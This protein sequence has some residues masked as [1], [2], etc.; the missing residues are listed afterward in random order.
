MMETNMKSGSPFQRLK[1]IDDR[2]QRRTGAEDGASGREEWTGVQFRIGDDK[3]LAPMAM[4]VEIIPPPQIVRVPGVK[5]WVLGLMNLHGSLLPVLDLKG[6]L[7]GEMQSLNDPSTRVLVISDGSTRVGIVVAEVFGM[8]HF[9]VNDEVNEYPPVSV[10]LKPFITAALKR[11]G[12]LFAV[13]DVKK[14]LSSPELQ[15]L[16][17]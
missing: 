7:F 5:N 17:V 3:L 9:W 10:R 15:N 14:L 11:Y 16:S 4:L 6:L 1:S 8:K 2:L 13:M 12:E